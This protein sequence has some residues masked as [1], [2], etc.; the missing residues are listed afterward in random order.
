MSE[1]VTDPEDDRDEKSGASDEGSGDGTPAGD[2]SP[3]SEEELRRRRM[4]S[5]LDRERAANERLRKQLAAK[6]PEDAVDAADIRAQVRAEVA[7]EH[8]MARTADALREEFP[9]AAELLRDTTQFDGPED[10]RYRASLRHAAVKAERDEL[11]EDVARRVREEYGEK[12]SGAPKDGGSEPPAPTDRLTAA[13]VGRLG[14]EDLLS[15]DPEE[16]KRLARS[17]PQE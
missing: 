8:E 11:A 13:T 7:R 17:L 16:L 14:L 3:P 4:Q 15:T 6:A 12:L 10:M 5:D 1:T 2:T 9:Y